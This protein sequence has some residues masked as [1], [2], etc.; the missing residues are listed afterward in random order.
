MN[1]AKLARLAL[2]L[3]VA[4]LPTGCADLTPAD[5]AAAGLD[6]AATPVPLDPPH[7]V[8][9]EWG[10]KSTKRGDFYVVCELSRPGGVNRRN[11]KITSEVYNMTSPR[12]WSVG[13]TCPPG[14]D[15]G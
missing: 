3:A 11:V 10:V 12:A 8:V 1:A 2:A 5:L 15:L 9:A 4:L 6:P 14:P 7:E 13:S